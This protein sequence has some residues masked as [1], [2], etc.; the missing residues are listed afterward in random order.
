MI[1][2]HDV[3]DQL[4]ASAVGNSIDLPTVAAIAV[5]VY[6]TTSLLHE[7]LGH[8]GVCLLVGGK[9]IR[10]TSASFDCD[11]GARVTAGKVVAAGGTIVNLVVGAVSLGLFRRTTGAS[12]QR[13]ALWLFA[14]VNIMVGLGYFFYS[15]LTNIG[16]WADVVR[17]EHPVWL[18]RLVIGAGGFGLYVVATTRLFARFGGMLQGDAIARYRTANH[19]AVVAYLTGAVVACLSGLFNPGGLFILAIS[20]A[21]ASLGGTSGLAWGAQT[22]RGTTGVNDAA[23]FVVP[24]SPLLIGIALVVAAGFVGVFGP[25]IAFSSHT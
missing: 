10:L 3:R 23:P 24:R 19:T 2:T 14:T 1:E 22:M 8:G 25:G 9:A 11:V 16:D 20:A 12:T 18:W 4:S 21:A 7:G 13:F 15:G 17:G 5:L 6:A